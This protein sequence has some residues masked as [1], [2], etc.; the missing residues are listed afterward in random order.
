MPGNHPTGFRAML[1]MAI[2]KNK[3]CKQWINRYI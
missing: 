1:N 2:S 3:H